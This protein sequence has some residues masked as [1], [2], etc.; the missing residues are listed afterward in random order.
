[1]KTKIKKAFFVNPNFYYKTLKIKRIN[2]RPTN[3][4]ERNSVLLTIALGKNFSVHNG[5]EFLN[6]FVSEN[7][8]GHKLGEFSITRRRNIFKKGKFKQKAT[9]KK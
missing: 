5:R 3:Y 4:Y 2:V 6:V 7:I 9:K 8:I 1:M